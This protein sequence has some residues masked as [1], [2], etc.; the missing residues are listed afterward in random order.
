M[1]KTQ[2]E[3]DSPLRA[4]PNNPSDTTSIQNH[5]HNQKLLSKLD[6]FAA[7]RVS[8]DNWRDKRRDSEASK[9]CSYRICHRPQ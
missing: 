4:N 1:F 5:V 8:R 7:A 3:V 9:F 6:K 2:K